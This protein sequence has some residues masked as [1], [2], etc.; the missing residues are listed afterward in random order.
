M[1]LIH[2][3]NKDW[4]NI[5]AG[6][7]GVARW[8]SASACLFQLLLQES[9]ERLKEQTNFDEDWGSTSGRTWRIRTGQ[10][11]CWRHIQ[12][13]SRDQ[14]YPASPRPQ[15]VTQASC[16]WLDVL[17]CTTVSCGRV[18]ISGP[19]L[20][21]LI[22]KEDGEDRARRWRRWSPDRSFARWT[23]AGVE[24]AEPEL[25]IGHGGKPD[26]LLL[27]ARTESSD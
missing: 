14:M 16:R 12:F 10:R 20:W 25:R 11:R 4:D 7:D 18:C 22:I 19:T 9:G 17:S 15:G 27:R 26:Q 23:G 1:M 24:E 13:Q 21:V 2:K 5:F 6:D 3:I 8:S